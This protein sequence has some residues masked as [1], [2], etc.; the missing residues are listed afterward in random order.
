[1]GSGNGKTLDVRTWDAA[2]SIRGANDAEKLKEF[3][4]RLILNKAI[5]CVFAK[6]IR[7]QTAALT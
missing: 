6:A 7:R 5:W 2:C 1:M 4:L 3:I